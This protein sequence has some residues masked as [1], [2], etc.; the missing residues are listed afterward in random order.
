[1]T[2]RLALW[3]SDAAFHDLGLARFSAGTPSAPTS[4]SASAGDA[5]VS[6]SWAAPV[7]DGGSP[8]TDYTVTL[9]PGGATQTVTGTAA[10]FTGLT[11]GTSYTASVVATNAVGDGTAGTSSAVTPAAVS[12]GGPTYYIATNG[13]DSHSGSI[14]SPWKTWAASLPKLNPGDT[15]IARDGTWTERVISPSLTNGTAANPITV[16]A[17]TGERPIVK[18]LFWMN[19]NISYWTFDGINFTWDP[20]TGS[21]S[22]HMVKLGDGTNW[23]LTNAEIWGAVSYA[24]LHIRGTARNFRVDNCYVHDN[25]GPHG[26]SNQDHLIYANNNGGSGI[27]ERNILARSPWGR[28][29]KV[30]PQPTSADVGNITIRYNTFYLNQGPSNVQLSYTAHDCAVYRNILQK[31]KSGQHNITAYAISSGARNHVYDNVGWESAGVVDSSSAIIN[32]GGN[33]AIDPQFANAAASDFH[34]L[35]TTAQAYGRYAP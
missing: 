34:P 26:S 29:V 5:T 21:S 25:S 8:V 4:I 23:R 19:S 35:N 9:S 20:A 28:G 22:E 18:G 7:S 15:L 2:T 30:G 33:L 1:M 13:S 17:A 10:T 16:K 24:C 31:P 11:N 12:G 27:I 3:L 6:V 14:T 32:D